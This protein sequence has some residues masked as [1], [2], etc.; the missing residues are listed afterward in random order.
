VVQPWIKKEK[1]ADG[2]E[3]GTDAS[4]AWWAMHDDT[5]VKV[6][7]VVLSRVDLRQVYGTRIDVRM[8]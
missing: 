8:T 1:R 2:G 5:N 7:K 6:K 3:D 4:L